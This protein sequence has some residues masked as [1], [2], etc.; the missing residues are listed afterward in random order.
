MQADSLDDLAREIARRKDLHLAADRF[1]IELLRLARL[2]ALRTWQEVALVFQHDPRF[3]RVART[4]D[5]HRDG[6]DDKRKQRRDDD[7]ALARGDDP[8]KRGEI[9]LVG[10]GPWSFDN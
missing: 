8:P 3:R 1:G 7:P 9:D 4:N 6:T 5:I 10:I 2:A